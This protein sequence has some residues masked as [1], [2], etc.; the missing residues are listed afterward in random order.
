MMFDRTLDYRSILM[1]WRFLVVGGFDRGDVRSGFGLSIDLDVLAIDCGEGF[2]RDDVRSGF[3]LSIDVDVLSIAAG[4]R[5][6]SGF[7]LSI[8]AGGGIR[9]N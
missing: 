9:P 6:R 8:D 1:F 4:G 2:D 5:T 7:C 3:G